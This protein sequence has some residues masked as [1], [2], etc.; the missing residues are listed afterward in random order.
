MKSALVDIIYNI[1]LH[2]Y[3]LLLYITRTKP[4]KSMHACPH[5]HTPHSSP[6]VQYLRAN[7]SLGHHPIT[8]G[9]HRDISQ[10]PTHTATLLIN[11]PLN[12]GGESLLQSHAG[13]DISPAGQEHSTLLDNYWHEWFPRA[14]I[15]RCEIGGL[16]GQ[17]VL[18]HHQW[19]AGGGEGQRTHE[20]I[21]LFTLINAPY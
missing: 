8:L 3:I 11:W 21:C 12:L 15:I 2:K 10:V 7:Y 14:N 4:T 17:P 20:V 9:T 5:T 1:N 18:S 13:P 6:T 16:G 19:M